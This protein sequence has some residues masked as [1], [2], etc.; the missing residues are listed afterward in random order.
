LK[1]RIERLCLALLILLIAA[2]AVLL[3]SPSLKTR[4][5]FA[6][7]RTWH[8]HWPLAA[9][10][11]LPDQL[12]RVF[13]PFV[14]I[15]VQVEPG[16]TVL[17]DPYDEIGGTVLAYGSYEQATV[18]ELERHIPRGGTFVDVGANIGWY[19]LKAARA[20]GPKGHVIAVEPDR[21]TLIELRSNIR[22]SGAASVIAVAPVACA[23]SETTLTFYAAPR[24]NTGESSLSQANASQEG[25]IAA[26]YPVRARRLDDILKEAG[27]D[28]VDA[29]KID[30]EGA[31]FLVL[32]GATETLD[33]YRPVVVMELVDRQLKAMGSSVEEVQ[34]FMRAHGYPP[35]RMYEMNMVYIPSGAR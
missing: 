23:D 33:R 8:A 13:S 5:Y 11:R 4:G 6:F 7:Y 29:M 28:R 26:S 31:E 24:R 2:S 16:M 22:A 15:W 3:L 17:L 10:K 32:K 34:A 21:E 25:A 19:S 12:S 20:A 35:G 18:R 14:P 27:V 1:R 30:V 9:G